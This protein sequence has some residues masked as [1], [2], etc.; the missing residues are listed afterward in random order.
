VAGLAAELFDARIGVEGAFAQDSLIEAQIPWHR[1]DRPGFGHA[2]IFRLGAVIPGRAHSENAVAGPEQADG[3]ANGG[4]RSGEIHAEDV[5]SRSPGTAQQPDQN[6]VKEL[7]AIAP[8]DA[9]GMDPDQPLVRSRHRR[10]D[11][12]QRDRARRSVTRDRG[13]LHRLSR[14][15]PALAAALARRAGK[16]APFKSAPALLSLVR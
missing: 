4:D 7:A 15:N 10:R 16:G 5:A 14:M 3:G 6:R 1:G 9:R 13:G 11:I 8:V 2:E 12:A